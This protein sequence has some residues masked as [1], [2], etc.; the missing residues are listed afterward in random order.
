MIILSGTNSY[1]TPNG[2]D[3]LLVHAGSAS[4]KLIVPCN[5]SWLSYVGEEQNV[6]AW[7][8]TAAI[9]GGSPTGQFI[10]SQDLQNW[11]LGSKVFN[12]PVN[13]DLTRG[14]WFMDVMPP[15]TMSNLL[16]YQ[17]PVNAP[18]GGD[19]YV[20]IQFS[21]VDG[22]LIQVTGFRVHPSL[23]TNSGY[24]TDG[25]HGTYKGVVNRSRRG[26]NFGYGVKY[27]DSQVDADGSVENM[28]D[29]IKDR[30]SPVT[31]IMYA[32][33]ETYFVQVS[34]NTPL[35]GLSRIRV[36]P[37]STPMI[38]DR[39]ARSL[40]YSNGQLSYAGGS[41]VKLT[42]Y[43]YYELN[44]SNEQCRLFYDGGLVNANLNLY[45]EP[46][47]IAGG[48]IVAT[49]MADSL[50]GYYSPAVS[51]LVHNE[52]LGFALS[53]GTYY[54]SMSYNASSVKVLY[55]DGVSVTQD[56]Y[57]FTAP[58]QI[59]ILAAN[60][61]TAAAYTVDYYPVVSYQCSFMLLSLSVVRRLKVGAVLRAEYMQNETLITESANI[62]TRT[63]IL[64]LGYVSS[65]LLIDVTITQ[66]I[67]GQ[68]SVLSKSTYSYVDSQH[69]QVQVASLILGALYIVSYKALVG[70]VVPQ[71]QMLIQMQT[72]TNGITWSSW[73]EVPDEVVLDVKTLYYNVLV[74]FS[75]TVST[76]DVRLYGVGAIAD[77]SAEAVI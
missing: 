62:D 60:F 3:G 46:G 67:N 59:S 2:K 66:Q 61:D 47:F 45:I 55:Q 43:G 11:Q 37:L 52:E 51:S 56:M 65:G 48:S 38:A 6:E 29:D 35:Y 34:E 16:R 10:W 9:S 8:A 73:F 50:H 40:L 25:L 49:N 74:T 31:S 18:S 14:Q 63:G 19:L 24:M 42:G 22:Y 7:I 39:E 69:L 13:N 75:N 54:A 57:S 72:S 44:G 58:N 1:V 20:G 53:G 77:R 28:I 26:S 64:T 5:D 4:L 33:D 23:G 21:E 17:S 71:A 76:Q 41:P 68:S 30:M 12:L 15:E 70:S 36:K 27:Y 32:H